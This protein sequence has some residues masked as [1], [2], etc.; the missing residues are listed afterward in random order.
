CPDPEARAVRMAVAMRDRVGELAVS[1]RRYGPSLGFGLGIAHGTATL[2]RI[3]FEGRFDYAVI[4]SVANLAAR[5]C[6]Q[7]KAGEILVDP[8]VRD[9]VSDIAELEPIGELTLKGIQRPVPAFN[10]RSLRETAA[11]DAN[12]VALT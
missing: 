3:G 6:A 2:G 8:T 1:W 12:R 5:L 10:V 7:A 9:A 11:A 4:G